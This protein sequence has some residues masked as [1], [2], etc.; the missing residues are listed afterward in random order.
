MGIS[1]KVG[2][3]IKAYITHTTFSILTAAAYIRLNGKTK[4]ISIFIVS[5]A[6]DHSQIA[7]YSYIF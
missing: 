6:K 1:S 2:D 5:E 3:K 4:K 7:S